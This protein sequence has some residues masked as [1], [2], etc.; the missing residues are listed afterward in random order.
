MKKSAD[1]CEQKKNKHYQMGGY[2][3]GDCDYNR[4]NKVNIWKR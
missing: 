2:A 1:A 3:F 4:K